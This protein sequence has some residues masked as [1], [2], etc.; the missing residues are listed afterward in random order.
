MSPNPNVHQMTRLSGEIKAQM[1]INL[2]VGISN[3]IV[4]EV[5]VDLLPEITATFIEEIPK[6]RKALK[7]EVGQVIPSMKVKLNLNGLQR[8]QK[9]LTTLLNLV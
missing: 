7:S 8:V 5:V 3:E 9:Q 1:K 2:S 6:R 4:G